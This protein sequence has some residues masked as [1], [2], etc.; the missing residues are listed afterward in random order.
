ML[1]FAVEVSI[2]NEEHYFINEIDTD[3]GLSYLMN[4]SRV[5]A[6]LLTNYGNI[7]ALIVKVL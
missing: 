2:I 6:A 5:Y 7:S 3:V 1:V 4:K